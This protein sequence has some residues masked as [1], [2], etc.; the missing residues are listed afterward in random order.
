MRKNLVALTVVAFVI[1]GWQVSG[2]ASLIPPQTFPFSLGSSG[3]FDVQ[4]GVAKQNVLTV[5]NFD[6]LGFTVGSG[7]LKINTDAITVTPSGTP[8]K[9]LVNQQ[10]NTLTI[11]V[12]V[13]ATGSEDTVCD[14]GEL[15]GPFTV[16]LDD[17]YNVVSVTPSTVTLSANAVSLLNSGAFVMCIDLLANFDGQVTISQFEFTVQIG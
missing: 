4:A 6:T 12:R 17:N 5:T 11:E 7:S 9:G 3:N 13:D 2:C 10:T 8:G 1:G 15:Y 16:E 14:T